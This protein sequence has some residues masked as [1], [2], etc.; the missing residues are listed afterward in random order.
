MLRSRDESGAETSDFSAE[1]RKWNENMKTK[2]EICRME[3]EM[4]FF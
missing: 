4:N 1:K 2:T 3:M